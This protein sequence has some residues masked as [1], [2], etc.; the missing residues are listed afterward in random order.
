MP[1]LKQNTESI[2]MLVKYTK[3]VSDRIYRECIWNFYLKFVYKCGWDKF[4]N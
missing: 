3:K 4:G 1:H 2:P